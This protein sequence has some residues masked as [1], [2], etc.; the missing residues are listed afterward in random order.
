MND[1]VRALAERFDIPTL[2][3][4]IIDR[5]G[6]TREAVA[7]RQGPPAVASSPYFPLFSVTKIFLAA[8]FLK[9]QE[10][11]AV[12]LDDPAAKWLPDAPES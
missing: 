3:L 5:L 1:L 12:D 8:L 9:A 2:S 4:A 11:G 7:Y 10:A 6:R